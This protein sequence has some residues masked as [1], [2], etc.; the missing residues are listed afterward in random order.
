MCRV[1]RQCSDQLQIMCSCLRIQSWVRNYLISVCNICL[2]SNS[3]PSNWISICVRNRVGTRSTQSVLPF[4]KL[5]GVCH[6]SKFSYA[7]HT[8]VGCKRL[9]SLSLER[10]SRARIDDCNL[11]SISWCPWA[12]AIG[13]CVSYNQSVLT[14]LGLVNCPYSQLKGLEWINGND[15]WLGVCPYNTVSRRVLARRWLCKRNG[16][17]VDW[18]RWFV[19]DVG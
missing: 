14:E 18:K 3:D 12:A 19:Q 2:C 4:G 17:K 6:F 7:F 1:I 9:D 13:Y 10:G 11:E 8:I 5:D 16:S 15:I